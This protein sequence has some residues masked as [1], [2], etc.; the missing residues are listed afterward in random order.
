[1]TLPGPARAQEVVAVEPHSHEAFRDAVALG[2]AENDF[3]DRIA[4]E[5]GC[6]V[7]RNPGHDRRRPRRG[8]KPVPLDLALQIDAQ[9]QEDGTSSAPIEFVG[10]RFARIA[11]PGEEVEAAIVRRGGRDSELN[12]AH[13]NT[14]CP[15]SWAM[16]EHISVPGFSASAR[17]P[18]PA[19]SQATPDSYSVTAMTCLPPWS[20]HPV[21]EV[22]GDIEDHPIDVEAA[23]AGRRPR[24]ARAAVRTDLRSAAPGRRGPPPRSPPQ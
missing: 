10:A 18:R 3:V 15:S 13:R 8:S 16:V 20:E 24:P 7:G 19:R 5:A 12:Q 23:T 21:V 4:V 1:M 2:E 14:T 22:P 17:S 9:E 6:V 11:F